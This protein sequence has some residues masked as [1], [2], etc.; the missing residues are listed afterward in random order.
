MPQLVLSIDA[1]TTGIAVLAVDEGGRMLARS[2]AELTQHYPR[3]GWVEHD[4]SEIWNQTRQLMHR[5]GVEEPA[6]SDR[7]VL[8]EARGREEA[9]G[10]RAPDARHAVG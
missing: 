6:L 10:D 4:P 9:A 7:V 3:P 8:G 1:G 2:Y 5:A